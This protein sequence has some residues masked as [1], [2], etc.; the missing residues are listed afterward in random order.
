MCR[1]ADIQPFM[2]CQEEGRRAMRGC[3]AGQRGAGTKHKR[4]GQAVLGLQGSHRPGLGSHRETVQYILG[5]QGATFKDALM[6]DSLTANRLRWTRSWEVLAP[7]GSC[8]FSRQTTAPFTCKVTD[9][10]MSE[11]FTSAHFPV[12]PYSWELLP[13]ALPLRFQ[14]L[15]AF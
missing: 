12:P 13:R 7:L 3:K 8:L 9:N 5:S 11:V 10:T 1:V 2:S 4:Q 14:Q 15:L 6:A